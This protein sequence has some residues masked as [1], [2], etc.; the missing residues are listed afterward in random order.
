MKTKTNKKETRKNK[1]KK[2]KKINMTIQLPIY[3]FKEKQQIVEE[4]NPITDLEIEIEFQKLREMQC[5]NIVTTSAGTV[6][7]NKIV[8]KFTFIER[9]ATKGHTGIDFY[10]FWY[11]RKEYR[12]IN[13]VKNMLNY[14]KTRNIT[15]I[16]KW[17]YIFNLYFSSI[18]IFRPIMAMEI[19]CIFQPKYAVLDPTMGW[20][21]RLVGACA[22]DVPKYI[23][24]DMNSQLDPLYREMS[25]F[26]QQ[27]S[28][29]KI[30]LFFQ[31]ALTVDYSKLEYDMVFT[32]PPYYNIEIYNG[33][34]QKTKEE[35]NNTFY[36]PLFE[37]TWNH[38]KSPGYYCLNI[39]IEIYETCGE[40]ILGKAN[41]KIEMKKRKRMKSDAKNYQEYIYI[42]IK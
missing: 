1:T 30:E 11:N 40:P 35:W 17:K 26:L 19:Y 16:R 4:L 32:S 37:R 10:T 7:G 13:Y 36:K 34:L 42:W 24:I 9:L 6:L 5:K 27:H 33:T 39:P 29:T 8:D 28:T 20:G 3:S 12:K 14:Y 15:E 31:D 21:G 38:M 25:I 2:Q 23:G 18:S 22:L 41:K